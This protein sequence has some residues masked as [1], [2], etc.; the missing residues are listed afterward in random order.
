M[1]NKLNIPEIGKFY[2]CYDDA[3]LRLS[4]QEIVKVLDVI[5]FNKISKKVLKLWKAEIKEADFLFNKET[6]YF[7]KVK[8]LEYDTIHYLVRTIHND[9]FGLGF[10]GG[11]LLDIDNSITKKL[12]KENYGN[13]EKSRK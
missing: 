11:V 13:I 3:K 12:N 4:K 6:D 2:F 9:W 5:P 7:I 8:E 10:V 1:G